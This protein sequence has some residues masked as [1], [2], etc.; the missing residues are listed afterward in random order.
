MDIDNAA[1]ILAGSILTGLAILVAVIL[2]VVVNNIIYRFWKPL[3]WFKNWNTVNEQ[4]SRFM[5]DDE[6]KRINEPTLN[7]TTTN[8]VKA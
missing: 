3:G 1:N 5:T 2:I 7:T 8:D 6:L 4:P